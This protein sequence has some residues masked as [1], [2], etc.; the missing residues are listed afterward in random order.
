MVAMALV[1][2]VA[3]PAVAL[4]LAVRV[5]VGKGTVAARCS[6]LI[7]LMWRMLPLGPLAAVC[8]HPLPLVHQPCGLV[9]L[10]LES[11]RLWPQHLNH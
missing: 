2:V 7:D 10:P 9:A 1:L 4:L 5:M 11:S 3:L 6:D 8:H